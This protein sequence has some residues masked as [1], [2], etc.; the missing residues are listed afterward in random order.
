M[1]GLDAKQS[2]EVFNLSRKSAEIAS[3][4][5]L[6]A[7]LFQSTRARPTSTP[8]WRLGGGGRLRVGREEAVEEMDG[9]MAWRFRPWLTV[10]SV[11]SQTV[12]L[13]VDS[14]AS[15][16]RTASSADDRELLYGTVES[17]C[18]VSAESTQ[19]AVQRPHPTLFCNGEPYSWST[20]GHR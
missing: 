17:S 11:F 8:G 19:V 9:N 13:K 1:R 7:W 4:S 20:G 15:G 5:R 10:L 12:P 2:A 18:K 14:G 6:T 3:R 16:C